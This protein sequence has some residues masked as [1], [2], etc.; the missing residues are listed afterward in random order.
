MAGYREIFEDRTAWRMWTAATISYLG[1]FVGLG[2]LLLMAYDRSGGHPLGPAAVFGV[3]AV[4]ALAVASSAGPWLDR[5]P[6]RGGLIAL[7]LAGAAGLT[8]PLLLGGVWPVL[9]AAAIIGAVRTAYNAIRTGTIA[10]GVPRSLRGRLVAAMN[11]ANQ[12]SEVVGYLAGSAITLAIGASLA[13][14]AD[15]ATFLIAALVNTGIRLPRPSVSRPRSSMTTGIRAIFGDQTLAVLTPA[16]W[17]GLSV[18]VVPQTLASTALASHHRWLPPAMAATGAGAA[19]AAT[20]VGR[21]GLGERIMAQFYYIAA[22]GGAFLLTGAVLGM[23]P[24]LLICGNFAIGLCMGWVVAAQTT[25]VLVVPPA[26][27]AH[28]T[29]T[30]IGALIVLEGA[31]ALAFGGVADVLGV[32]AAYLLAGA[33]VLVT[34]LA[35]V[36]YARR[37]PKVLDLKRPEP[38]LVGSDERQ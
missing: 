6:R 26:R 37:Q 1:D 38:T 19:I 5:I 12:V 25:F 3:Q 14:F 8:L 2:A 24:V 15:I 4:P 35:G 23:Q 22:C 29:S 28:A 16:V 32:P 36:Q 7:C 20:L 17:I 9:A 34:G 18:G 33:M 11:A 31:G 13:L 27:I 10:D 21:S 30:M